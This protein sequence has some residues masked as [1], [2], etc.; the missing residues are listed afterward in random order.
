[1]SDD[2]LDFYATHSRAQRCRTMNNFSTMIAITSG[3]NT[4]PIRR[5]KRTWDQVNQRSMVQFTAC[6]LTIDSN[7]TFTKYRQLMSSVTPPCV[8][9]IG[10]SD[11]PLTRDKLLKAFI[12]VSSFPPCNSSRMAILTIL[13][14]V[15]SIFASVNWHSKSST[16]SSG[17]RLTRSTSRLS[18]RSKI[19]S[20]SP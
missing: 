13:R 12:Q 8:P 19:I 18:L 14:E 15:W 20:T 7:K 9:F 1:M 16:T 3:L 17:G 11:S 5:L 2:L 4:P 6:E 10:A